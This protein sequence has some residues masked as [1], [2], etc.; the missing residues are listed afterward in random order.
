MSEGFE[1]RMKEA[2]GAIVGDEAMKAEGRALQRK[3]EAQKEAEQR[4]KT[5]LAQAEN[6]PIQITVL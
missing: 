4:E 6:P 2:Y 5:R 1:G 3:A